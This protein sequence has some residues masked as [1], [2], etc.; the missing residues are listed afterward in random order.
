[1]DVTKA[2]SKSTEPL[3]QRIVEV[4]LRGNLSI[5]LIL[6]SLALGAVALWVTPREEEPQIVVPLADVFVSVPGLGADEVERLVTTRL[7]KLL[8][9]IDGVEYV[10]SMSRPGL[11]IVTVRFYVGE[12]RENSLVKIYN[13][14][15]SNVDQVPADVAGW[16]VKPVE[17]DDVPIVNVT[18]WSRDPARYDDYALRRIAEEIEIQLQ[19]VDGTSITRVIGGR[20]RRVS[21]QLDPR[22]LAA[23]RTAPLDVAWALGVSNVQ[24]DTNGFDQSDRRFPVETGTFFNDVDDLGGAVVNV[25]D[26]APV[27]LKEVAQV[28]DGPDE[29]DSYSWIAFGPAAQDTAR[30]N[31]SHPA[32]HIT[33]AKKK[34]TNAVRVARA[35]EHRMQALAADHLPDGVTYTITRDYGESANDKVNELVEGLGMAVIIVIGLIALSLGWREAMIVSVAVPI[36]FSLTLLLNY[37]LGYTINRVTLFALTLSL[38]LVV[39]D[40]IVDVENIYRHLAMRIEP[41]MRAVLSAVREVR[42]PIILATLAVIVSFIPMF[43]IT[44]MMGPYMR[45][46][47]LNVPVAML[48]SMVVAF[49]VTPWMSYHVL[50]GSGVHS[51]E[52]W[53]LEGSRTYRLYSAVLG[54]LLD[55]RRLAFGLLALMAVL[56]GFAMWLAGA[57]Q[58]PLK[59]LPFD[60][61]KEFQI[62]V[63]MPEGTTL[64]RTDAAV[65]AIGEVVR[66]APE[67]TDFE[68]YSGLASAMDFNGL[69]RHYYLRRGPN[70]A[71]I[72]V[73]LVGKNDRV[74]QSHEI[75]LRLRPLIQ[76][77]AARWDANVKVVESPPGPPVISTVTAEIYGEAAVPYGQIQAAAL[78]VADR[79][80]REPLVTDVDTTVEA[81]E[82]KWVFTTDKEKAA[83][84]G[85]STEDI[86]RTVHLALDGLPAAR[87]HAPGE[88]NP[89]D[90]VLR[91]PRAARSSI[92]DLNALYLKGRPGY[93]QVRDAGGL[94]AASIP[95]VQLGELGTFR[96]V[97]Q[98]QTIYHKNLQRVAYVFA[99]TAGRAPA[100][101]IM[102]VGADERPSGVTPTRAGQPRRLASRSYFHNGGGDPW[103]LPPGTRAVWSGEGEWQITL[104]VFRD[105]GLAFG[106]ACIGIYVLLVYQTGSYFMPLILMISIPLT[107]IGIMPG[108][109]LLNRL[110]GTA[111]GGF[112]N[113]VFFT[114]TAMIGMIAL[115][116]IAV[117]NAIL[118]I[119]FAHERLRTGEPLRT[120]LLT[121]GAVRLR[122][123]LL[124]SAAAMLG[125]FPITLD[126]IFSGLAWALI[127]GLFV[128]TAFTL[129]VIPMTYDLVYRHRPGHGVAVHEGNDS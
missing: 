124:T 33:V 80:H 127:F 6:V 85:I 19:A 66:S 116:G 111:I 98:D 101:A 32:V 2:P 71:D 82:T 25:V 76:A 9:Q 126:P 8:Y 118:L 79:L 69:V 120:A 16:V 52:P 77:A 110:G 105:L 108:F 114:A 37:L 106:A 73:N 64:E 45:P 53:T 41:P 48:M 81:E 97:R 38:G 59:M 28:S 93:V 113:P 117:R 40:P 27:F 14:V 102:D 95:I 65:R 129:V 3:T 123:I 26:G 46:M 15:Q 43:F 31:R 89:L 51:G 67:V 4:F 87:L 112:P 24:M 13:K 17:I 11:A 100:E 75:V 22:A 83:L 103:S 86:G 36:T 128:S 62:V 99:E 121:C 70:V 18:L 49:T 68:V 91:L 47:A 61:K 5:L 39:D 94:R 30:A 119:E 90:I 20:P 44:G 104:D 92:D 55:S 50:R 54:P 109:W 42:P 125:A 58:V 63:D 1:M 96:A 78:T 72:R 23:R 21:V 10:Y 60:N 56:F 107:M 12:N 57:R 74:Q 88:V 115:S 29:A 84:S 34:G 7:E 35:I 122:P